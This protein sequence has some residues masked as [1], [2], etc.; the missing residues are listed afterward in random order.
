M[1]SYVRPE[2]WLMVLTVMAGVAGCVTSHT[3]TAEQNLRIVTEPEEATIW[4]Q[5]G[6]ARKEMGP[7]P[8]VVTLSY[9]TCTTTFDRWSWLLLLVPTALYYLT[10][11]ALSTREGWQEI[12]G[13]IGAGLAVVLFAVCLVVC[14]L[15]EYRSGTVL[16]GRGQDV[17]VGA[18]AN[19]HVEQEAHIR[20]PWPGGELRIV[21]EPH[22]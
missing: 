19:G 8:V 15:G 1:G 6:S 5:D 10:C 13:L 11:W 17:V 20:A 7:A 12:A 21:L 18:S 2:Y 16:T 14:L 4:Q 3:E 9:E 22:K